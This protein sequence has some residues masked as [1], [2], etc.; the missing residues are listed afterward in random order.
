[1]KKLISVILALVILSTSTCFAAMDTAVTSG[2][3]ADQFEGKY[4]DLV[5]ENTAGEINGHFA[6]YY[7][8]TLLT[9]YWVSLDYTIGTDANGDY[10]I[11]SVKNYD[12]TPDI[13]VTVGGATGMNEIVYEYQTYQPGR[14][15]ITVYLKIK[16]TISAAGTDPTVTF[17]ETSYTYTAMDLINGNG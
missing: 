4:Y 12:V 6:W 16:T 1:M 15:T 9:K 14:K 7:E 3:T 11:A 17:H 10:F 8:P 2:D 5:P 13:Y